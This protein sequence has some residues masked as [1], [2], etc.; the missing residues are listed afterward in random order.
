[1]V[2]KSPFWN[3]RLNFK[4][5]YFIPEGLHAVVNVRS[6]TNPGLG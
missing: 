2:D 4:N 3:N 1:M 5:I 6:D